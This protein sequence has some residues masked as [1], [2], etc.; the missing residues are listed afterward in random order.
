MV[1]NV[2]AI[3]L[4]LKCFRGSIV[5]QGY[6]K[7]LLEKGQDV[8]PLFNHLGI[9]IEQITKDKVILR[10]PHNH[11]FI[12]GGG[13]IA[14]GIMAM[15]ADEAM[16]H[17]VLANLGAGEDTATIEMNLRFLKAIARGDIIAEAVL[18]KKGKRVVTV[19]ADVLD[20]K[21]QVLARAGA[22]FMIIE[23]KQP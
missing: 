16:A 8:N 12:Q 7:K 21:R 5:P 15:L 3:T 19:Q 2:K 4:K 9:V 13:V 23:R 1:G 6:L 22:S 10:L 14:G 17:V 11:G 18:V 20:D